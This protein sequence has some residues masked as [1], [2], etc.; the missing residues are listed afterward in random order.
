M[1]KHMTAL[2]DKHGVDVVS[3]SETEEED[4]TEFVVQGLEIYIAEIQA[5]LE[6]LDNTGEDFGGS[7]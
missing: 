1:D 2:C 3:M 6:E 5:D 7:Y 4:I